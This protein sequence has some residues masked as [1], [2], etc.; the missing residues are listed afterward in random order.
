M[1]ST[2]LNQLYALSSTLAICLGCYSLRPSD[3]KTRDLGL[4]QYL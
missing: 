2:I 4:S 3:L 1:L